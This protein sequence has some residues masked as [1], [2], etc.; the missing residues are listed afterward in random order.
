MAPSEIQT[1]S[2]DAPAVTDSA[3]ATTNSL[4]QVKSRSGMA[5]KRIPELDGLRGAAIFFVLLY[6]YVGLQI[7]G[8]QTGFWLFAKNFFLLGWSGVDLFFVLSGFLIGGILLDA[9][10]SPR[11]FQTFY[12]RRF[13]RIIPI[14]YAWIAGYILL[15]T[16]AG[17]A[18]LSH[19]NSGLIAKPDASIYRH[20]LFLQNFTVPAFVGLGMA[21]F[22]A[23]W[24]LAVEEQFYLVSP[25]IVR[26]FTSRNLVIFLICMIAG[27]PL[28]RVWL[29]RGMHASPSLPYQLMP[30]RADSLAIGMLASFFWRKAR[31]RDRVSALGPVL[32]GALL[33]LLTGIAILWGR[34]PESTSWNMESAGF[35]LLGMCYAFILLLSL[36]QPLGLVARLARMAW[37]RELGRVSYCM[38]IVHLAVLSILHSFLRHSP[39]TI[40]TLSGASV[41]LLAGI[42]TY[43]TAW[44]SW[45]LFEG[46]LQR[47]GHAF[48]Y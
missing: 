11:Y 20:F 32:Y 40:M 35:S 9:R 41:T 18:I 43:G 24:S 1:I 31:F 28:L 16:Y 22:A 38:Y 7:H 19:S 15:V 3:R 2:A 25:L 14:Y 23:L 42:V 45:K 33:L 37:L 44:L 5:P 39:P 27:A 17:G 29:L 47:F 4:E 12:A 34:S 30:C 36:S 46:P 6:H 26:F 13:F 10:N 48:R 21:W 8:S